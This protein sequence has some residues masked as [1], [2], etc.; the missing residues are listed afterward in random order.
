ME[1]TNQK[2]TADAKKERQTERNNPNR[3]LKKII[4]QQE[5]S[6]RRTENS[7]NNPKTF[8]EMAISTYVLITLN[9]NGKNASIKAHKVFL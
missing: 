7:K 5:K 1:T 8:N 3:T 2:P 4:R 9:V 6:P